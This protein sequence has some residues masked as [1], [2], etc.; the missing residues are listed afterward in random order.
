MPASRPVTC[1]HRRPDPG[2]PAHPPVK[3]PASTLAHH[4]CT[5]WPPRRWMSSGI[6]PSPPPFLYILTSLSNRQ[7]SIVAVTFFVDWRTGR[8]APQATKSAGGGVLTVNAF[9]PGKPWRARLFLVCLRLDRFI[10]EIEGGWW[11]RRR[12]R[13]WGRRDSSPISVWGARQKTAKNAKRMR[14]K[15][16]PPPRQNDL[17]RPVPGGVTRIRGLFGRFS[18]LVY[19]N[20]IAG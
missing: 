6:P 13:R 5:A 10:G 8:R 16:K 18:R 1:P 9:I 12:T 15:K 4:R 11:S 14:Q 2:P 19:S 3:C 20:S 17:D 7:R